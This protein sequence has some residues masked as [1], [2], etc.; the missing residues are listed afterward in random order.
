VQA[1]PRRDKK[2]VAY[3]VGSGKAPDFRKVREHLGRRLPEYMVPSA[4]IVLDA[5][6]LTANGKV[7]RKALLSPAKPAER[8]AAGPGVEE[9]ITD[10]WS[11]TLGTSNI[12]LDDDFFDLGGTSLALINVVVEMSKRFG[13]P[14]ET[15]IVA[16]GATVSA[17]AQAVKEKIAGRQQEPRIEQKI[18]DIWSATLGTNNIGLDDDFFDLGGTSLALINVVMEMSKQFGRPLETSIVTGG[19]TVRALAQAV[20]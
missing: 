20:K 8:A 18:T 17:L 4:M 15:G 13:L 14:L 7:D 12:G 3:V 9:S 16:G 6:P 5:L 2:L 10:I 1:E 11:A 19:A